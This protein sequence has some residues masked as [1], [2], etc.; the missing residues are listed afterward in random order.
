M[1][2]GVG[3]ISVALIVIILKALVKRLTA[4]VGKKDKGD[5]NAS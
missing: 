5:Q 1:K 2:S 4:R 3:N